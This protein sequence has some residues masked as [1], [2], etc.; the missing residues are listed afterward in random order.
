MYTRQ[1]RCSSLLLVLV[2]TVSCL[3]GG[4]LPRPGADTATTAAPYAEETGETGEHYEEKQL[5]EQ[6][7]FSQLE[8]ELFR[9][10]IATTQVDLH[11]LLK[12][13]EKYGITEAKYLYGPE[14]L[15]YM[16]ESRTEREELSQKLDALD[17]ALLTDEQKVTARVLKSFL[18][19]QELG[20]GLE[21]YSQPLASTIGVQAELPLLLCE[22]RFYKRQDVEDYLKLLSGIDEYYTQIMEFEQQKAAAGL[23]MSDTSIDHVIESCESYLLVPGNNFM[24]DTFNSRLDEVMD[25]TEAEKADYKAQNAAILEQDFV[26]AYQ[27]LIDGLEKLKGSGTNP[28][29]QC[30]YPD[31]K[32]YYNYL[33]FSGTGTS[34]RSVEDLLGAVE[35]NME[36]CLKESTKLLKEHPT[37]K[38]DFTNYQFRQTEPNAIMEEL[39]TVASDEFPRLPA[40]NYTLK[41]VPKALELSVSPAFYLTSPL[42]DVENNV[43]YINRNERYAPNQLYN[44]LAHEGYPGHLY[45]NVYFHTNC[46]SNL[47]KLLTFQGYNEGWAT[48]V[49]QLSYTQDNG[50]SPELG[51]MLAANSMA[52]LGLHACLDIYINYMGW[53]KDQVREYLSNYYSSPDEIVDSLYEAMVENPANYLSYYVG[54]MEFQNMRA[55][56]EK[57]LGD[58][59]DAKEF[60]KFLL[61]MGNAPFDVIQPYFSAWLIKQKL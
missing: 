48:Y 18:R 26:P 40:C 59:F 22:Y 35:R 10:E 56:A 1:Q 21:L 24:I 36:N 19:T 17:L 37:L 25:V 28:G 14:T 46:K 29:G 44:T 32:A 41:D 57:T 45:Q 20:D 43:I 12:D 13:P 9:K 8:E 39:K 61:D 55:N 4:C 23:M 5:H 42:D 27:L 50:L 47:R 51:R 2:L 16:A 54:C 31:G 33:V 11:F 3:L 49:E 38:D 34:Y 52:S 60:H 30:G 15:E 58:K 53:D 6:K 7:K